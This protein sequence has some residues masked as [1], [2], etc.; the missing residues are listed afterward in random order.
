VAATPSPEPPPTRTVI[1]A[2]RGGSPGDV[3]LSIAQ[4]RINQRIAQAG[5]R[6]A[7]ELIRRMETGFSGSDLKPGTLTAADLG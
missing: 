4:L 7:N 1:P 5:V 2:R 3:T 6:R